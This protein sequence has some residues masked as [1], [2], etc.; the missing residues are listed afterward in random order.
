M[1]DQANKNA[2]AIVNLPVI[3][4]CSVI[5]CAVLRVS[6]TADIAVTSSIMPICTRLIRPGAI[7][8]CALVYI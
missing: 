3:F 7:M 4:F 1:T 6:T 2:R 5:C 8:V